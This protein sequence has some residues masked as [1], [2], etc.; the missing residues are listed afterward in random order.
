MARFN[1]L[2]DRLPAKPNV[3]RGETTAAALLDA[4][5]FETTAAPLSPITGKQMTPVMCGN[6]PCF[7]DLETRTVL[8]A[9]SEG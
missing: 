3:L 8:P 9:M 6:V 5:N 1:P 2:F 4:A 7:V